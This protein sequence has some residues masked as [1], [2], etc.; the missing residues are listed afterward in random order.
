MRSTTAPLH[1]N[2][3]GGNS[4][5]NDI[6]TSLQTLQRP[7]DCLICSIVCTKLLLSYLRQLARLG[8]FLKLTEVTSSIITWII[9]VRLE[10]IPI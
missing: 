6:T 9:H 2:R 10:N 7:P 4:V 8:V 3:E 5:E 1:Y